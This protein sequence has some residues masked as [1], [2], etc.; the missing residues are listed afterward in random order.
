MKTIQRIKISRLFTGEEFLT[1]QVVTITNGQITALA[2]ESA[3]YDLA[4]D[5]LIVPGYIDLQVNGGGGVLFN[6][7]PT[8][9]SLKTMMLAHARFGTTAMLPTLVTD[10]IAVMQQAADAVTQAIKANIA[11]IIGIHFEGP[12]LSAAKKGVH[13]AKFMR[14][15]SD[16][17]WQI[18]S[19]KDLGQILVTIA[20]E[21]VSIDDI[22]RL[23]S[24][25]VKVCLG[26]SNASFEVAEQAIKAGADGITHLYNAMS[27]LQG[28][29]PG[30]V[31]AAL[32]NDDVSCGLIVDGHHVH[33]HS[34]QLAIKTK[35]LGKVFLV[36]D[37]M[38]PVGTA[39]TEF[40][41]F[42]KKV[43]LVDGKLTADS[44][45]LA[46]SALDMAT[47][48]KNCYQHLN[49]S[50]AQ[51]L[52]MA[53]LYPASYIGQDAQRGKLAVGYQADFVLLDDD[54][55]VKATWIAGE[56]VF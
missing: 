48:V 33:Y 26:H 19:R 13:A 1:N 50:L 31:G 24:L 38:P 21:A 8:V 46:G 39:L 23:V 30:V 49:I 16:A 41:F 34:C 9:D 15:I 11:G 43:S 12:H 54:L 2:Q 27:P 45:E 14:A 10:N 29:E 51:A 25:G 56:Q 32:L 36:T 17:E 6:A 47:A 37:A 35:P 5:G 55:K 20:P 52:N 18:Y 53:S 44:G 4:L 7:L 28:R 40:D 22:K 3:V 42:A